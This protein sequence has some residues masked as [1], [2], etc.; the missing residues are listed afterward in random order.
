MNI[1]NAFPAR[2]EAIRVPALRFVSCTNQ[3]GAERTFASAQLG[4]QNDRA[5]ADGPLT[6]VRLDGGAGNDTTCGGSASEASVASPG[7][8]AILGGVG[9]DSVSYSLRSSSQ[10][11]T[12]DGVA[13]DGDAGEGDNVAADVEGVGPRRR[14]LDGD[15]QRRRAGAGGRRRE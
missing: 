7:A 2:V 5:R 8:D 11:V 4:D 12:L 10:T 6:G 9:S 13:N 15:R 1:E 3:G 14:R